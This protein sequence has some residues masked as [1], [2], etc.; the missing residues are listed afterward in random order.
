[1]RILYFVYYYFPR[2]SGATWSAYNLSSI[3]AEKN[4]VNLIAPNIDYRLTLNESA[5]RKMEKRN[6]T[7]INITPWFKIPRKLAPFLSAPFLFLKGL[8]I[9]R[10]VDVIFCQ[11]HPYHFVFVVALFVGRIFNIPVVARANDIYRKMGRRKLCF[12][13]QLVKVVNHF[14]ECFVKYAEAFLVV[15]SE[16]KEILLSRLG[17]NGLKSN[18]GLSYNGVAQSAFNNGPNKEEARKILCIGHKKKILLFVG[19]FSGQEY[20]I[21]V[22]LKAMPFVLKEVPNSILILV[23]DNITPHQ[24]QLINSLGISKHVRIYG[25]RPHEEVVNFIM[26]ADLCI[27]PLYPT[28]AIPHKVLEY[29]ICGK[30]VITG[31]QSVS[32][33]LNPNNNFLLVQPTPEDVINAIKKVL[34]DNNLAKK[35]GSNGKRDVSNFTWTNIGSN[36]E[37]ILLEIIGE[38]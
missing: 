13:N 14:N 17:K 16:N 26:A 4:E 33:D 9:G 30:P 18:I 38:R 1:M 32:K 6:K 8:R 7:K 15:C 25:V 22:L 12:K 2:F 37:N 19:R 11:F 34:H 27:G 20:G 5:I 28:L 10:D 36:L 24:R 31:I 35:L 3:L 21:E 23:G 29:M